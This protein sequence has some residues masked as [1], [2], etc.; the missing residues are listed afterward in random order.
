MDVIDY[1]SR[2]VS[3]VSLDVSLY[4]YSIISFHAWFVLNDHTYWLILYYY[5]LLAL[6]TC[7]KMAGRSTLSEEEK[8]KVEDAINVL[9]TFSTF[10]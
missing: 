7:L 4:K 9:T 8:K 5:Y 3:H 10:S 6:T 1:V 2:Y